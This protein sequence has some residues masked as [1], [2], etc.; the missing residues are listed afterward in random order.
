[1]DLLYLPHFN[2]YIIKAK[3]N[4]CKPTSH[5]Y[6]LVKKCILDT[7]IGPKLA[8][9]KTLEYETTVFLKDYIKLIN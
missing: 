5:S 9:F 2:N 1:M 3:E 7:F 8:F 6:E 4:K